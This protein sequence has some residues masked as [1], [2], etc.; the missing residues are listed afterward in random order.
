MQ[1]RVVWADLQDLPVFAASHFALQTA[2]VEMPRVNDLILT[3]GYLPPPL[4]QGS[5]DEQ[6]EA[7]ANVT[8]VAIRPIARFSIPVSKVAELS[9]LLTS[10][11]EQFQEGPGPVQ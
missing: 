2:V 3:I 1:A 7:A 4:L 11:V 5:P 8:E 6:R 10:F 9:S